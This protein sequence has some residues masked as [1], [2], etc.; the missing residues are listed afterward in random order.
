MLFAFTGEYSTEQLN[1]IFTNPDANRGQRMAQALEAGGCKLVQYY[2][3]ITNGPGAL[4]IFEAPD[5]VTAGAICTVVVS[6]G[7]FSQRNPKIERLLS[8]E[9]IGKLRTTAA[10]VIAEAYPPRPA[11]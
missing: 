9:D 1:A 10:R 8:L 4:V 7:L 6:H 5:E 11:C 3:R 2:G